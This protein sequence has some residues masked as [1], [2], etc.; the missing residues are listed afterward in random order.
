MEK[1]A[2]YLAPSPEKLHA[3]GVKSVRARVT[4]LQRHEPSITAQGMAAALSEAFEQE[5]G[6]AQALPPSV[7]DAERVSA[8]QAHYESWD[9]RFG[10]TP[11]FDTAL[12]KRFDW[13][14]VDLML[15]VKNG[16]IAEAKLYTDSLEDSL[17]ADVEQALL[18]AQYTGAAMQ[19]RLQTL[20]S[21]Q[22]GDIG[23]WL[24]Q[25]VL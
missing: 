12:A 3:K 14:G 20:D 13:G 1:L 22:A 19:N 23:C 2:R 15:Q 5:Y 6:P 4:N 18:G 25:Q 16:G 7:L 17:A 11:A 9:W 21:R 24:K 8:L 10:H